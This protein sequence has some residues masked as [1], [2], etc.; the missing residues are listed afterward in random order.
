VV[1]ADGSHLL[2]RCRYKTAGT[3]WKEYCGIF[4]GSLLPVL[5]ALKESDMI[6]LWNIG[7]SYKKRVA[8]EIEN[9]DARQGYISARKW[10]HR[11]LPALGFRSL[12]AEGVETGET[13]CWLVRKKLDGFNGR[14]NYLISSDKNW[15]QIITENWFAYNPLSGEVTTHIDLWRKHG[16]KRYCSIKGALLGSSRIPKC[17]G[18]D[19]YNIEGSVEKIAA[20]LELMGAGVESVNVHNFVADGQL[21]RNL[22]LLCLDGLCRGERRYLHLK[23]AD[24]LK[25][26]R[27]PSLIDWIEAACEINAPELITYGQRL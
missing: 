21:T 26:V 25:K 18:I 23:Y 13:A 24:C 3:D 4:C 5:S 17:Y 15:Q 7:G 9:A 14:L 12:A 6:V 19:D 16:S 1:I 22:E 8:T 11:K 27:Q 2:H 20:G 10:L